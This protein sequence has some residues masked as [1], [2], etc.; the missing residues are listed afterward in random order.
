MTAVR[1]GKKFWDVLFWVASVLVLLSLF[2]G[3]DHYRRPFLL[4]G[5]GP[6]RRAYFAETLRRAEELETDGGYRLEPEA[7]WHLLR[8]WDPE[9]GIEGARPKALAAR[10][11][12]QVVLPCFGATGLRVRME[13]IPLPASGDAPGAPLVVE[14]GANGETI[15]EVALRRRK[16]VELEIPSTVVRRGDNIAFLYRVSR[17]AGPGPWLALGFVE[18]VAVPSG[19]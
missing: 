6:D 10:R 5:Y 4:R 17:W 9:L 15:A 13:L 2:I 16:I 11:R 12:A 7:K 3:L 8:G 14:L 18:V 1:I 19:E